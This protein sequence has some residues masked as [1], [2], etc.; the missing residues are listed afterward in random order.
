MHSVITTTH[1]IPKNLPSGNV[2]SEATT[3]KCCHCATILGQ[4]YD[5]R[6]RMKLQ[7]AHKCHEK[8]LAKKPAASLPYN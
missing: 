1:A 7:A 5:L 8:K 2:F 3:V 4:A 6:S